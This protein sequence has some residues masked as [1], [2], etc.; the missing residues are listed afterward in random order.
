MKEND[1]EQNCQPLLITYPAE[2]KATFIK[3]VYKLLSLQLLITF[4]TCILIVF[5]KDVNDF[6]LRNPQINNIISI[7][8][9]LEIVMLSCLYT[10]FP[11]NIIL[12]LLFT[13]STSYNIGFISSIYVANGV[14]QIVIIS[15][16]WTFVIFVSLTYYVII[17]KKDFKFLETGLTVALFS[18]IFFSLLS[19]I[20][21]F[22]S[23]S[24]LI[25][26]CLGTIVFSGYILYDTSNIINTLGP[27]DHIIGVIHLYLDI[28]NLFLSILQIL[29]SCTTT[30]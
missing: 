1:L 22:L 24:S 5:E 12:M 11:H 28:I 2:I 23:I 30:D 19:L 3:K 25:W 10:K 20:L 29:Q 13:L 18:M 17:T 15:L 27:D 21:P 26:G 8:S 16:V 9:I 14:G 6:V 7:L 4:S